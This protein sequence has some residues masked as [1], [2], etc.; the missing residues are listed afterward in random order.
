MFAA[1]MRLNFRRDATALFFP[2]FAVAMRPLPHEGFRHARPG[3]PRQSSVA[4][5]LRFARG[6]V[7]RK[8]SGNEKYFA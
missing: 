4:Q 3:N 5:R 2:L 7:N 8:T 1:S 6:Y